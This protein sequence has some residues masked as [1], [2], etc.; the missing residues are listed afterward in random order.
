MSRMSDAV[1]ADGSRTRYDATRAE[2]GTLLADQPRFR[3]DQLWKGLYDQLAEPSELT[4]LPKSPVCV[5]SA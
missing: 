3:V 1:M 2:L 4:T 5:K